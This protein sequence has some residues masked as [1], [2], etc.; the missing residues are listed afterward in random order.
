[1]LR[2][3]ILLAMLLPMTG[4]AKM[5]GDDQHGH[6]VARTLDIE[7]RH[8][9]YQVF[10]PAHHPA[11]DTP[12]VLFL[13]GSGERGS[14]GM[15]QLNAGLGPYLKQHADDFPA[16]VVLPQVPEN[17]EWMGI[18]AR[19]ALAALDAASK[20]FGADSNRTYLTGMSMGGY[21]SWEVALM[22]PQR[23]AALA[24]V[25]GA[26][27]PPRDE[28]KTL[29]VSALVDDPDPYTTLVTRLR[30]VPIWIFHGAR[31]DLV[32][33]EDDRRIVA[34]ARQLGVEI[35]YSEYPYGN[36]NAWDASY[37]DP[38][39]WDWMFAQHLQ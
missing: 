15:R 5:H 2:Y 34:T 38:S 7:G 14:D 8:Y 24:V 23:F 35:R 3:L 30:D 12:I 10:V 39:L 9:R 36:H 17:E 28:R 32:P 11:Q 16:L 26:I 20:E 19:M 25:C 21:G 13:H 37:N 27:H 18:N 31:D 33:L 6:F 22:Q 29:Y 4:W 1:M